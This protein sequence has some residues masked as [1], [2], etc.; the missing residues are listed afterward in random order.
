MDTNNWSPNRAAEPNMDTTDW[1]GQFQ[2]ESHQL[3]FNKM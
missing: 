3:I 2:P 1:R